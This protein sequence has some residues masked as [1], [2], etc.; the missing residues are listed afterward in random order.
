MA[1][2]WVANALGF[3]VGIWLSGCVSPVEL[4][5][6]REVHSPPRSL[7]LAV[8]DTELVSELTDSSEDTLSWRRYALAVDSAVIDTGAGTETLR[9]SCRIYATEPPVR[10][11]VWLERAELVI[12]GLRN[13][14]QVENAALR[15]FWVTFWELTG[16]AVL[17]R[18]W[19]WRRGQPPLPNARIQLALARRLQGS[20][21]Q[22]VLNIRVILVPPR[23]EPPRRTLRL[24]A[25]LTL[26]PE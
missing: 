12:E 18:R 20:S 3:L 19:E 13:G 10:H 5:T 1:S 23:P 25:Q 17:Q 14:E 6:D 24:R 21:V 16:Q 22:W 15:S 2:R 26:V 7:T 8:V 4:P 11:P 9:L